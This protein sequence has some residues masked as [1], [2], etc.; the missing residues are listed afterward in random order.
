M[1]GAQTNRDK[2][3]LGLCADCRF[4]QHIRS[5]KGSAF[6]LCGLSK[7]D[8]RFSK[9]PRLPVLRCSGYRESAGATEAGKT[10]F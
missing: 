2:E 1:S 3:R 4:A 10:N 9:Y 6:L 5:S 8:P 7:T